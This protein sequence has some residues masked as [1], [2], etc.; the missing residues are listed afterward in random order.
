MYS[1]P[2]CPYTVNM[3]CLYHL[4][5]E[6]AFAGIEYPSHREASYSSYQDRLRHRAAN[7]WAWS[8]CPPHSSCKQRFWSFVSSFLYSV[9]SFRVIRCLLLLSLLVSRVILVSWKRSSVFLP[10]IFVTFLRLCICLPARLSQTLPSM[11]QHP[12][13][14]P[15]PRDT[16]QTR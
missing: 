4:L 1:L 8:A 11:N 10:T 6:G 3:H 7:V 15:L 12:R 5:R 14:V 13:Q 16:C 9:Y 2:W